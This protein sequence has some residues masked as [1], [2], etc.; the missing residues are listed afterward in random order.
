[1]NNF[2]FIEIAFG[3]AAL[4]GAIGYYIGNRGLAGVKSDLQDAKD[5]LAKVKASLDQKPTDVPPVV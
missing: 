4:S 5:D 3:L 1:M 2:N